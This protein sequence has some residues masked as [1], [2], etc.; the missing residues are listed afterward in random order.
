MT[1]TLYF[2]FP[3]SL[4]L[5]WQS[6]F[7][8]KN[9]DALHASLEQMVAISKDEFIKQLFP[10][11]TST[12]SSSSG[13]SSPGSSPPSSSGHSKKLALVSVGSK[14]RVSVALSHTTHSNHVFSVSI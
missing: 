3:L 13:G 11:A 9:N 5:S 1:S 10:E 8:E 4:P 6:G 2:S 14:F 12:S 7:L